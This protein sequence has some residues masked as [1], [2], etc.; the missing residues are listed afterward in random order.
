MFLEKKDFIAFWEQYIEL[1][2]GFGTKN[3][4]PLPKRYRHTAK[5]KR[6]GIL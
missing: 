2:H 3:S 1:I 4:K 5:E 6:L